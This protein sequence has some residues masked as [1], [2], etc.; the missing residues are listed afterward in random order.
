MEKAGVSW[1]SVHGRTRKQHHQ[2]VNLDAISTVKQSL[3]IPVVANGD[4]KSVL[5]V[6]SVHK[7]TSVNGISLSYL[8]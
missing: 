7:Q 1:I 6:E 2:P 4:I 3:T 5:D 8:S